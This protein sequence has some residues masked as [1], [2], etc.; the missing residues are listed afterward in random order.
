MEESPAET[1]NASGDSDESAGCMGWLKGCGALI[2]FIIGVPTGFLLLKAALQAAPKL[3]S[4]ASF[5]YPVSTW[6][7]LFSALA[8][9]I[10][11]FAGVFVGANGAFG[12]P[13][14]QRMH[15]LARGLL[16]FG[17]LSLL[18]AIGLTL[19]PSNFHLEEEVDAEG[20]TVGP[21]EV[22]DDDMR[23]RV[24]LQQH[25]PSAL[26]KWSF[27]T[28]EVLGDE[29]QYLTGF[30]G[31]VWRYSGSDW[32][33]EKDQFWATL[34]M[35]SAGTYYV[36]FQTET[37]VRGYDRDEMQPITFEM[38]EQARWGTPVPMQWAAYGAFLFAGLLL[39]ARRMGW[40][41]AMRMHL[42]ERGRVRFKGKTW[43][44]RGKTHYE[45]DD[46]VADEWTL[47]P[48]EAGASRPRYLEHEYVRDEEDNW[49]NWCLSRPV[50][51]DKLRCE[52]PE[53]SDMTVQQYIAEFEAL[54]DA[55]SYEGQRYGGEDAG[56]VR[57]EDQFI[58]Y[59]TYESK[60]GGFVTIE[61]DLKGEV[62]AVAG[63]SISLSVLS[64]VETDE[65]VLHDG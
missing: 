57:R 17:G 21:I 7:F 51:L 22:P 40:K 64:P 39:V 62:E 36:R 9:L 23:V 24:R 2:L 35:A 28:V 37:N 63:T 10:G 3:F 47:M 4:A 15:T 33:E 50:S 53:G 48:L 41:D 1:S 38:I 43:Q 45:Y 11:A 20:G 44:P 27:I 26:D 32:E 54:P 59:A 52:G 8:L 46:W 55:V 34:Q 6:G 42:E 61:E 16:L 30:G 49:E 29:N 12:F 25:L 60:S 56:Q 19:R 31:E 13:T 18:T 65:R 5:Y 58:K 14:R